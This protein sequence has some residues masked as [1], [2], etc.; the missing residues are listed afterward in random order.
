MAACGLLLLAGVVLAVRWRRYYFALPDWAARDPRMVE[1][2]W[3]QLLWVSGVGVLTGF[4]VGALVVGPGG[5]LV[6]RLLAATSPES[7][8]F[9]TEAQETVGRITLGGTIGFIIFVGLAFGVAAGLTYVFVSFTLPHGIVGGILFG[10]ALLVVFGS[11]I[12]PLVPDNHDFA[13][14]GPGWLAVVAFTAL[15]VLTG[16]VTA[17]LAGRIAAA[18]PAPRPR[19]TWWLVPAAAF[20]AL[21]FANEPVLLV[22]PVLGSVVFLLATSNKRLRE[23][24]CRRGKTL[25]K[26]V[27][28]AVVLVSL[29]AFI[30]AIDNILTIS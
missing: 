4:A 1:R 17:P 20:T 27:L 19:W 8:G 24:L 26:V 18:L 15:A 10:A 11:H 21:V 25:L 30:S 3:L 12:D 29:P 22:V 6:M 7:K 14:V 23:S 5:R 13:I 2:P 28:A 9:K 16:A